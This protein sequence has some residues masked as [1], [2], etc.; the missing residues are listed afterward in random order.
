MITNLTA[1]NFKS[2]ADTGQIKIAPLTGF[3]GT[4]S[5]GKTAILQLLL[6]LKQ[7][8]EAVDRQRVLH[9]GDDRS[10][11]DLGT[12]ADIV[13]GHQIP[14]QINLA[15]EWQPT[16]PL[17]IADPEGEPEQQLFLI[18]QLNYNAK[19]KGKLD[20]IWIEEFGYKFSDK[21]VNY[22]FG[23]RCESEPT[24]DNYSNY[25]LIAEGYQLRRK[26]GRA[27]Q[28][29]PPVQSYR[30]PDKVN[31]YYQNASFLADLSLALQEQLQNLYYLGP[32]RDYPRRRYLW[33]GDNP[34]DV[35]QKGELAIPALL[36]ARG[37]NQI[38]KVEEKVAHWLR[39]LG[40]IY[41]FRLEP[42]AANS[43]DYELRVRLSSSA[44]EVLITDVGFG[45]SQILPVLVLCYYA[46]PGATII[47]EQPEIH[48]HPSVQ[49]GL[50]DVFI[51]VIKNQAVQI[52]LE[53]HSEH[54]LRRLQRRVAEEQLANEDAALYFCETD[55]DGVAQLTS[56]ELDGWGNINNWPDGF[57]GDE[58][59]DLV[60]MTEA[61][62]NRQLSFTAK[63]AS[64]CG[65]N[66][67]EGNS[68]GI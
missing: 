36:A 3:F 7:T 10:Y 42:I 23:M 62:M 56:L 33:G 35:G 31:A 28:L 58:M 48:L 13:Y 29:P 6:M 65:G 51:D 54:L 32:L 67:C 2:W 37:G 5:S 59:G 19:I 61:A 8:V 1:Q 24:A 17:A 63:C 45:V 50:A 12:F 4:N 39:E 26:R 38:S 30:F 27:W 11:I 25:D 16:Q 44:H 21:N 20:N 60:A 66:F 41:D 15:L 64:E 55:G 40:L 68:G 46:P 43:K 9:L 53:S 47:L 49:A 22:Q 34:Q 14:G 57:F 18:S 52:I